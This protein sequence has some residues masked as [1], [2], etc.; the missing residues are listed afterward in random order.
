[1]Q[2]EHIDY[3]Y[4]GMTAVPREVKSMK[5]TMIKLFGIN[6]SAKQF[7][8]TVLAFVLAF[9]A[10]RLTSA[11]G[12][13]DLS[14][15]AALMVAAPL[16]VLAFVRRHGL[17]YA[18]WMMVKRANTKYTSPIRRNDG[19]NSYEKLEDIVDRMDK[20]NKKKAAKGG[21]RGKSASAY[22]AFR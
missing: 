11:I 22:K 21:Q 6:F 12:L 9:L 3:G 8:L 2:G 16:F 5:T 1:M 20:K 13:K 10:Y 4:T 7:G 15:L 14:F 17:E 19:L 18:D